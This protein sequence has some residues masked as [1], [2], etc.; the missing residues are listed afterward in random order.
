MAVEEVCRRLELEQVL[1]PLSHQVQGGSVLN[2]AG[3]I[4]SLEWLV[5]H[6]DTKR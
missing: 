4:E 2:G 1:A 5:A 6:A 3:V